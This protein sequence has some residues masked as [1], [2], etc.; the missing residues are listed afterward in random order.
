MNDDNDRSDDDDCT[1][2]DSMD[3]DHGRSYDDYY[4]SKDP[5]E[6]EDESHFDAANS[7]RPPPPTYVTQ[8]KE[9]LRNKIIGR[10]AGPIAPDP[11][12]DPV[13]SP[14]PRAPPT[15]PS[16]NPKELKPPKTAGE[17][18]APTQ[19]SDDAGQPKKPSPTTGVSDRYTKPS[20]VFERGNPLLR[21]S[22]R[23]Y[24]D[25]LEADAADTKPLL[26]QFV[27]KGQATMIYAA[28][29]T[30]K[31]L[32]T[33]YLV[34]KAIEEGR[35]SP[36]RVIYVNADDSSQGLAAKVRLLED[37]GAHMMAPGHKNMKI[38]HLAENMTQA[39]EDR[40]ASGTLIIIDTL[41][42]YTDLMDKKRTSEFGQVCREY[43]MAG[44]TV[45]A[46]GHTRKSPKADGSPQYQ[47]TTDIL[48][49]FDAVYVAE[50]MTDS[51][52]KDRRVVRFNME[53]KRADSPNAVAYAYAD[54]LGIS[55]GEK[56]ESVESVDPEDLTPDRTGDYGVDIVKVVVTIS[57][58]I[59]DG[60]AGGKG[61]LA[62]A[63]AAQ[64]GIS[65]RKALRIIEDK[66]GSTPGLHF[67]N[68]RNGEHNT[69]LYRLLFDD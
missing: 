43:V 36:D 11:A 46:L 9:Y 25:E 40:S 15:S 39:V 8:N 21:Y 54:E 18:V 2:P 34:L 42:K 57:H 47:G 26:G 67:W 60:F 44:G 52:R 37:A 3:D 45:V 6:G 55:Y 59:G 24:A 69:Q 51:G 27:M 38:R 16:I 20:Q 35:I 31:T 13:A 41:K 32:I 30:G 1:S 12:P 17:R 53:K 28:P 48:E 19:S 14:V 7:S 58:I 63:T 22:L 64:C 50:L 62:E 49:D 23:G 61:A 56:L 68:A 10:H 33:L 5:M 66:T 4:E 29:N 65:K